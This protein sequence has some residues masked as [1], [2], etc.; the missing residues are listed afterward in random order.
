M[1]ESARCKAPAR[2]IQSQRALPLYARVSVEEQD[3][4]MSDGGMS[5]PC[6]V[7][8]PPRRPLVVKLGLLGAKGFVVGL[9]VSV[10]LLAAG[11]GV[12]ASFGRV[13]AQEVEP[14]QATAAFIQ[15]SRFQQ[16]NSGNCADSQGGWLPIAD[17]DTCREASKDLGLRQHVPRVTTQPGRPEGCYYFRSSKDR[18]ETLWLG[19]NSINKGRGAMIK[20]DGFRDPICIARGGARV[21]SATSKLAP[22]AEGAKRLARTTV[23][24]LQWLRRRAGGHAGITIGKSEQWLISTLTMQDGFQKISVGSCEDRGWHPIDQIAV[25]EAAARFLGLADTQ[26]RATRQPDRP[27]GCYVLKIFGRSSQLWVSMNPSNRGT[28]AQRTAYSLREPICSA[29]PGPTYTSTTTITSRRSTSMTPGPRTHTV[30]TTS[31]AHGVLLEALDDLAGYRRIS[32][33]T[34]ADIGWQPI[35]DKAACEKAALYMQMEDTVAAEINFDHR[36]EGCYTFWNASSRS[37]S[38]WV[39]TAPS[40][41]GRG[42]QVTSNGI[43]APICIR[44]ITTT[45]GTNTTT[46]TA[47][48]TNTTFYTVTSTNTT[49]STVTSTNTTTSTMTSTNTMTSTVTSTNTT[50]PTTT[51]TVS[52]TNSTTTS[53]SDTS[54]S[55]SSMSTT[56]STTSSSRSSSS[57]SSSS[58][59]TRTRSLTVTSTDITPSMRSTTSS[60]AKVAQQDH[61]FDHKRPFFGPPPAKLS[62]HGCFQPRDADSKHLGGRLMHAATSTNCAWACRTFEIIALQNGNCVCLHQPPEKH[63]HQKVDDSVCGGVCPHEDHLLPKR[64]CGGSTTWAVFHSEVQT[65]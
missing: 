29:P 32:H 23:P 46:S 34:C 53:T 41:S 8:R 26:A 45:T 21:V 55:T 65:E 62:W 20:P 11:I 24:P 48:S 61:G 54:T 59:A 16:L 56:S 57:S 14:R 63:G 33:G 38:L 51:A 64:Y 22:F 40:N 25:C 19:T 15:A 6:T 9:V 35:T 42:A 1:S 58:T 49:T 3:G 36:P 31:H 5:L 28:G 17:V 60:A 7:I 30:T 52:S 18:S 13:R 27:E 10:T 47:T 37:L 2:T 43:R 44:P 39:A 12:R 4:R 50:T